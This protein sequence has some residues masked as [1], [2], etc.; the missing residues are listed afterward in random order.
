MARH[1]LLAGIAL[2][3]AVTVPALANP[4]SELASKFGALESI[5]SIAL[6]P[7]G[8]SVSYVSA[9]PDGSS[10]LFM[11][12]LN[13]SNSPH[14]ILRQSNK[15]ET[16][17]WCRWA[18]NERLVCQIYA[19]YDNV[20]QLLGFT[21][22]IAVNPDG[23]GLAMLTPKTNIRSLGAAQS[24]GVVLDWDLEGKPG[25][26]LMT[27]VAVPENSIGTNIVRDQQ[28]LAV[29]DLDLKP[30]TRKPIER[31]KADAVE[32]ISD[33]HGV[34]RIMGTQ[35]SDPDGYLHTRMSYSFRRQGSR[36]WEGLSR[37]DLDKSAR[38]IG[39]EPQAVD[40]I[41]NVAYGFDD[42]NGFQALYSVA[43]DGTGT[44]KVVLSRPDV[45]V[46]ELIQIGRDSR[47]VG[48]SYAT[49]RRTVEFFD[50]ELK[51]LGSA[52]QKALPGRPDISYFD[53]SVGESKLLLLASSD[54][55]PGMFYRYDK[56]SHQL[57]PIAP[58]RADLAG[59]ELSKMQPV[60]YKTSDGAEIPGYLTLPLHSSG[61]GLPA[62]VMPHGGPAARDEWGFDWLAQF[63]A[64]RGYAVL[65]P[66]YRG[67]TGYGAAW[68]QKNGFQ[69]WKTAIGDIND[70]GRWLVSQGIAAPSKL[71][72]VGW[73]YGGYAAL[74]SSVLDPDLYKAIVAV[75]PVTD[76]DM[77]RMEFRD[78]AS[79]PIVDRQIGNGPHVREGSPAQNVSRIRA[80]VLMFHGDRDQNV[81]VEESRVMER[82]LKAEGKTVQLVIFPGLDHQIHDAAARTEMLG[83]SDAFL[84]LHLGLPAD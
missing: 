71:A 66:N 47:V 33:G 13:G 53:A 31:P 61:K 83:K 37:I 5:Q 21:R 65:Q 11:A 81:G 19:S 20:G 14:P 44:R 36:E 42:N 2:A 62:I 48:A 24:G 76:L 18:S 43:L 74:Q 52:L 75:A 1:H 34:V 58:L 64:A 54:D 49:D 63:F 35:S 79:F 4:G 10:V 60:T 15:N 84:R 57:A 82:R 68:Y 67:S 51:K 38:S 78:Y 30:L 22:M 9:L 77:L 17:N 40:S 26:V 32:Y 56:A 16:L 25:H 73:S 45:D 8:E 55:N 72:I 39:F 23:S 7:D 69:S 3:T 41:A 59:V 46:D 80:P 27:R 28:G 70:A 50:P 6:S 29:D 12:P